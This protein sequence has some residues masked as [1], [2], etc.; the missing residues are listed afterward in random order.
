M[1]KRNPGNR[2]PRLVRPQEPAPPVQGPP[3]PEQQE[4]MKE[5]ALAKANERLLG[6]AREHYQTCGGIVEVLEKQGDDWGIEVPEEEMKTA[7]QNF[8]DA[9]AFLLRVMRTYDGDLVSSVREVE[10]VIESIRTTP[11][12]TGAGSDAIN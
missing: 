8:A 11:I 10:E 4:K 6:L 3:T 1:A 2:G 12:I 5:A 7:S 9:G